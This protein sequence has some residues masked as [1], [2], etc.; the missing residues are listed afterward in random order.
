DAGFGRDWDFQKVWNRPAHPDNAF[1][2][3]HDQ[4]IATNGGKA[5][6]TP[7][8]ATDN[9]TR[10]AVEFIRGQNRPPRRPWLLWLCYRGS[11]PPHTPAERHR[12]LSPNV[13][14]P[15]PADIFPPR[16][17]KPAYVQEVDTWVKN[18]DGQPVLNKK[19][20]NKTLHDWVRQYQQTVA[21]LDDGV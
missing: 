6:K 18:A 9:Y 4:L 11:R 7:G 12:D 3:Y 19:A 13:K 2:Y 8:Y 21:A 15:V 5:E 14:V 10:W 16:R 1:F 20:A 17:G